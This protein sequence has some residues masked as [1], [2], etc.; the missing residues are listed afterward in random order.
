VPAEPQRTSWSPPSPATPEW[1]R[2]GGAEPRDDLRGSARP[3]QSGTRSWPTYLA[4]LRLDATSWRCGVERLVPASR[5]KPEARTP[6]TRRP[7]AARSPSRVRRA[8]NP[9]TRAGPRPCASRVVDRQ[10]ADCSC[11]ARAKSMGPDGAERRGP[12]RSG[13]WRR[14]GSTITPKASSRTISWSRA[15]PSRPRPVRSGTTPP[16]GNQTAW[17]L[18]AARHAPGVSGVYSVTSR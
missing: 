15:A 11:R 18:T 6:P 16:V 5:P 14:F 7:D 9:V 3:C 17:K 2:L 1:S 13:R 8:V 10:G 4:R 12:G